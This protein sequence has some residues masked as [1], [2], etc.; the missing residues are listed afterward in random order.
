MGSV[1]TLVPS[2]NSQIPTFNTN[3][4]RLVALKSTHL[5]YIIIHYTTA[6]DKI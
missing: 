2:T 3:D 5:D 4:E 1:I 6:T